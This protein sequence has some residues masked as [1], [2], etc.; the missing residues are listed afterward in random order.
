[1]HL[2]IISVL[3][4]VLLSGCAASVSCD[5]IENP[6]FGERLT[7]AK[8]LPEDGPVSQKWIEEYDAVLEAC[9]YE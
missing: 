8:E 1:M 2:F 6:P 5:K 4:S 3:A 9:R 7:L